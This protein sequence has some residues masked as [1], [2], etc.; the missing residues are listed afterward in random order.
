[1]TTDVCDNSINSTDVVKKKKKKVKSRRKNLPPCTTVGKHGK[2]CINGCT[3]CCGKRDPLVLVYM[4]ENIAAWDKKKYEDYNVS[5]TP[6]RWRTSLQ[7]SWSNEQSI[8]LSSTRPSYIE[9][10]SDPKFALQY[11]EYQPQRRRPSLP[12]DPHHTRHSPLEV[13]P[14]HGPLKPHSH[15]SCQACCQFRAEY[16]LPFNKPLPLHS[17]L[18]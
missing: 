5:P 2:G 14:S 15:F 10:T 7:T 16:R 3:V 6:L 13:I 1:M 9:Y 11:S 8:P 12:L 17:R 18:S 4:K